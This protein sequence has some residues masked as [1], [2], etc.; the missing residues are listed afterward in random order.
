MGSEPTKMHCASSAHRGATAGRPTRYAIERSEGG[1]IDLTQ[2]CFFGSLRL[3][4]VS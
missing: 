3:L 2:S 4:V 1:E